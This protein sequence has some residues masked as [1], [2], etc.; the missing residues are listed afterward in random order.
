LRS[1]DVAVVADCCVKP[2]NV[3]M[4]VVF[5]ATV[6]A[7]ALDVSEALVTML[8]PAIDPELA[9][10]LPTE[11]DWLVLLRA[12][13][14]WLLTVPPAVPDNTATL[15]LRLLMLDVF[16]AI[17]A[18]FVLTTLDT[19]DSADVVASPAVAVEIALLTLPVPEPVNTTSAPVFD[20]I[21][22][23]L[24][25]TVDW[26]AVSPLSVGS[27]AVA[28]LM[29]VPSVC[30]PTDSMPS[31]LTLPFA[32]TPMPRALPIALPTLT[33]TAP[34]LIT[35]SVDAEMMVASPD[36]GASVNVP[37]RVPPVLLSLVATSVV[38]CES[39]A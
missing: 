38:S 32:L 10:M 2:D 4:L 30:P 36:G 23:V 18:V 3:A 35:S 33:L 6:E 22:A 26:S 27:D 19:A 1:I 12:L 37:L 17:L 15:L 20:A 24:T 25:A 11:M 28:L 9:M 7:R 21:P 29:M 34:L 39:E 13:C 14:I 5:D 16:V 31:M 8:E